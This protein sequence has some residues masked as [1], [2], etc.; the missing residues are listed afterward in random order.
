MGNIDF[1]SQTAHEIYF[2]FA[3]LLLVGAWK[4]GIEGVINS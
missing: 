1:N 2:L 4:V 3:L